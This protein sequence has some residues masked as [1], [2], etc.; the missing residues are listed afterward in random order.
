MKPKTTPAAIPITGVYV[1]PNQVGRTP[2]KKLTEFRSHRVFLKRSMSSST[3]AAAET[4]SIT[5]KTDQTTII[6]P[7]FSC[8]IVNQNFYRK[9]KDPQDIE[10][11]NFIYPPKFSQGKFWWIKILCGS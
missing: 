2:R 5:A 3:V 10:K 6:P 8:P 4:K 7:P 1:S 9:N 11:S